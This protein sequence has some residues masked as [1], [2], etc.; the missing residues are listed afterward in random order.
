MPFVQDLRIQ[1][2]VQHFAG[3]GRIMAVMLQ[4]GDE[5]SLSRNMLVAL[6]DVK[7]DV[8]ELEFQ[9]GDRCHEQHSLVPY[10]RERD[11]SLSHRR[12]AQGRCR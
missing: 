7:V 2:S 3:R 9:L 6:G 11:R 4:L 10:R 12:L 1:E 8:R 5:P